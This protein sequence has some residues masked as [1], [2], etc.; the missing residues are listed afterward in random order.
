MFVF[1]ILLKDSFNANEYLEQTHIGGLGIM[2]NSI[3]DKLDQKQKQ[4]INE[5][6]SGNSNNSGS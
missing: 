3:G 1:S 6:I 2:S 5:A 4:R